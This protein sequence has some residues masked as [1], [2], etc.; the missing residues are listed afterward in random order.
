MAEATG[1]SDSVAVKVKDVE[2]G[3]GGGGGGGGGA[4]AVSGTAAG[5]S[6]A[7]RESMRGR[8]G[9][10]GGG[11]RC[12]ECPPPQRRRVVRRG[13]CCLLTVLLPLCVLLPL[14]AGGARGHLVFLG[15]GLLWVLFSLRK[16]LWQGVA[17]PTP[18]IGPQPSLLLAGRDQVPK[19]YVVVNPHG[20]VKKGIAALEQVV[21]PVWRDEFGIE[22]TVLKTEYAGTL[23]TWRA[24]S[25]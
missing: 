12:L 25:T 7:G 20:G 24:P 17:L 10:D 6:V 16:T 11:A 15:A 5:A 22:V 13:G 14:L 23:G 9:D 2:L 19:L 21:L 8:G 4:A 3:G 1:V 18:R